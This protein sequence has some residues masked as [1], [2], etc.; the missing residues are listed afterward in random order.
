MIMVKFNAHIRIDANV[1]CEQTLTVIKCQS[2]TASERA[3][4]RILMRL[5]SV[6]KPLRLYNVKVTLCQK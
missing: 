4:L 1:K 2:D 5:L 3:V 6:N